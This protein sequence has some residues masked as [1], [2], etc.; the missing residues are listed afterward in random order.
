MQ[1]LLCAVRCHF[2]DVPET[3]IASGT[4]EPPALVRAGGGW[5]VTLC[6]TSFRW[7]VSFRNL[8]PCGAG[9]QGYC[10]ELLDKPQ[11]LMW[12]RPGRGVAPETLAAESAALSR[13]CCWNAGAGRFLGLFCLCHKTKSQEAETRGRSSENHYLNCNPH[14]SL[15]GVPGSLL[16]TQVVAP[17]WTQ[18]RVGPAEDNRRGLRVTVTVTPDNHCCVTRLYPS[19]RIGLRP[20]QAAQNGGR[21]F[22]R[23]GGR[24][25]PMRGVSPEQPTLQ[26]RVRLRDGAVSL[27][28]ALP[29]PALRAA[30]GGS[31]LSPGRTP[32]GQ[33]R[34]SAAAAQRQPDP[35]PQEGDPAWPLSLTPWHP[36]ASGGRT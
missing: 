25:L 17:P 23:E 22:P 14:V 8:E 26:G 9:I 11:T 34:V 6:G 5:A 21:G 16:E 30:G 12:G 20:S 4:E 7:L 24:R 27:P 29:G 35:G 19:A 31:C 13:S 18:P 33:L 2:C 3:G 15:P 1:G 36:P 10:P 28:Q 32:P